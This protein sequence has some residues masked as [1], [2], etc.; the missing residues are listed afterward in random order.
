MK[1][2]GLNVSGYVSYKDGDI[3]IVLSKPTVLTIGYQNM[4]DK[5]IV[6]ENQKPD[7]TKLTAFLY[8]FGHKMP[9]HFATFYGKS[10]NLNELVKR[11]PELKVFEQLLVNI[12]KK[13]FHHCRF[14]HSIDNG[15]MLHYPKIHTS[16][17]FFSKCI[18]EE[19][20]FDIDLKFLLYSFFVEYFQHEIEA[21]VENFNGNFEQYDF[22]DPENIHFL[23]NLFLK[24]TNSKIDL[25]YKFELI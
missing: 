9:V 3:N 6:S 21:V 13:S 1:K 22:V 12:V 23:Q 17:A 18:R 5:Q 4:Q 10:L 11:D 8:E 20:I 25:M 14:E 24:Y 15:E 16:P 2:D 7:K 19:N